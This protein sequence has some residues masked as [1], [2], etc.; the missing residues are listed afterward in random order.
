MKDLII[1]KISSKKL[2]PLSLIVIKN[3][4]FSLGLRIMSVF[5]SFWSIR[6]AYD[7]TGSQQIYGLWLTILSITSWLSLLNGGL[8]NGL[9]NKLSNAIATNNIKNGRILVS[10]SYVFIAVIAIVS[11]IIYIIVTFLIDWRIA[12]S[13]SYLPKYEF[14]IFFSIIVFS[15]LFQLVLS[16]INALCFAHNHSTLPSLFTFLSSLLYVICLYILKIYDITGLFILGFVYCISTLVVLFVASIILFSGKYR[17]VRPSIKYFD[18]TYLN[19]LMGNGIKFFFLEIS[20]V[21]IFTTDSIIITHLEGSEE[22]AI[23]QLVMKLFNI[24]LIVSGSIM[25]PLWSAYTHAYSKGDI[26]WIIRTI[27]KLIVM[28]LLLVFGVL[29][30]SLCV[31][32]IIKIWIGKE[33]SAPSILIFVIACYTII[34]IWSNVFASFLNGTNNIT[35]QLITVGGG[36][37]INIPLS[38]ILAKNFELGTVGVV[39]A[40]IL[41]LVPF[42]VLGPINSYII[43]KRS[44]N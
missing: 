40:T 10:T 2:N 41:C 44:K 17:L 21:I 16:T 32:P 7:F 19:E 30:F 28:M 26:E 37:L 15:F 14:T 18:K 23:Y 36:A 27:K 4:F 42:S 39:L 13:A 34:N 25:V 3:S 33:L 43:I 5:L 38:I 31:N 22:V 35:G 1:S 11:C 8:G 9:R 20:A 12:F 6:V 24:F 29:I